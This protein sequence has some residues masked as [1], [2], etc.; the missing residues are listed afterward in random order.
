MDTKQCRHCKQPI[1]PDARICQHCRSSQS[2]WGSQ[3]DLRFAIGWFVLFFVI[4]MPGMF[5][6]INRGI[7]S[8]EPVAVPN[9]V[10]SDVSERFV[11]SPEGAR[12][13]VLGTV[14]NTS[15]SDASRVWFRVNVLNNGGKL[16]ESL[17]SQEPGLV[18]P[19]GK[20]VQFRV[21]EL[22]SV[23]AS[24]AARTEVVVE[25]ARVATKWD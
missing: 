12:L 20:S 2:W 11:A 6:F 17:L 4:F 10:V 15:S 23:P 22:L 16:I 25:R 7:S 19:S 1:H 24:E 13:F 8:D 5:F 9:L 18:V 21:T 14:R 3:R